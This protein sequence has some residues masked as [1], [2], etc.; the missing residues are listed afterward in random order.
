MAIAHLEVDTRIKFQHFGNSNYKSR[1]VGEVFRNLDDARI[2]QLIY[3]TT[4]TEAPIKPDLKKSPR[5]QFL[6][7]GLINNELNIQAE[8]L[9]MEDLNN[10]YRGAIVP[11]MLMQELLST[12][13]TKLNKPNFWVREKKQST[14]EVDLVIQH[15]NLVIPIEIKSGKEGKLKS[16]H[17]FIAATNHLYA[18]RLY[19]GEFSIEEHETP[20]GKAYFLM[21]LPYYLG[22]RLKDYLDYFISNYKK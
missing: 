6:D 15:K 11:H 19:A 8:M 2:I 14:A 10:A 16:L 7:T 17:Q 21:N 1:E 12:N 9:A 18:V 5:L 13:T 4:D 22:T 3:P 20:E